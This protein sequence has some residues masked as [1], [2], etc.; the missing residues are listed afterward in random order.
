MAVAVTSES[1]VRRVLDRKTWAVVGASP[2]A[3]RDSNR[4]ALLLRSRGY[5]VIPVNPNA[6]EVLGE[7][8]YPSVRDIS[9]KVDVVD[10]FRRADEAGTHVDEAIEVGAEA[11]WMQLGVV[12]EDA[13]ARA[14]AAGLDVV[15]DRCPAI[16]IPRLGIDGPGAGHPAAPPNDWREQV[17]EVHRRPDEVPAMYSRLA[18]IYEVWAKLTESRARRGVLAAAAPRPGEDVL[19]VATGTGVQLVELARRATGGRVAGVELAAGMLAQTR[20][21]LADARLADAVELVGGSALDLPFEDA[22]FD[23]VV[24]SYMLDLLPRAEIPR[25][26]TE[27][28][29]VLRPGGRLVLSNMTKGERR[30]HRI[31]DAL[32]RRGL[33]LTANCRG[34]LAVPVLEELGG[35]GEVRREYVAQTTFPTEIVEAKRT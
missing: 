35:F 31:W 34:V 4:I 17:L 22:S 19:E 32:Y 26:L 3:T 9:E 21:R 6:E 1:D 8:A 14:R 18:P 20:K 25:A 27:M 10:V 23:L 29:R 13:A 5:R 12:D 11:V 16:E 33:N 30:S 15:M 28:K 7:R 2:D 24:N